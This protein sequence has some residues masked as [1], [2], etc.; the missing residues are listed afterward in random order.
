MVGGA[1][2]DGSGHDLP[3]LLIRLFLGMGLDLLD[4]HGGLVSDLG[5]HLI[6]QILLGLLGSETADALQHLGLLALDGLNLLVFL[7]QSSVLGSKLLLLLLNGVVFAV[8]VLFLLLQPVLLTL[9]VAS[10]LLYFLLILAA[11]L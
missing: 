6:Q 11:V 3:G 5:L 10:A 7:V 9:Q 8:Q 4:L 2:L 1:A